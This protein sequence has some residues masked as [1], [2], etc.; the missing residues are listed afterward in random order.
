MQNVLTSE[1]IL[2]NVRYTMLGQHI[3]PAALMTCIQQWQIPDISQD[4]ENLCSA[5]SHFCS[6]EDGEKPLPDHHYM[7]NYMHICSSSFYCVAPSEDRTSYV[8]TF[9]S[10]S[11]GLFCLFACFCLFVFFFR[12]MTISFEKLASYVLACVI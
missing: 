11:Q 2:E 12:I 8:E 3:S 9:F 4:G 7:Q 6:V 10:L 5:S 1:S